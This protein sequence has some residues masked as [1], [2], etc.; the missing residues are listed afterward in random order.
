VWGLLTPE[1]R[2]RKGAQDLGL[3]L[4]GHAVQSMLKHLDILTHWNAKLNLTTLQDPNLASIYHFLDSLTICKL[5]FPV[6]GSTLLDVGTGAGFPGLPLKLVFPELRLIL[7]EKNPKKVVFLKRACHELGLKDVIFIN[8][9]LGSLIKEKHPQKYDTVVS[10]AF[11]SDPEALKL[12]GELVTDGGALISMLGPHGA[13]A[14]SPP[15]G[16]TVGDSWEG[17]LPFSDAYRKV[18]RLQPVAKPTGY[19]ESFA[20]RESVRPGND[21]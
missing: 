13:K 15:P 11:S 8:M 6:P 16:F 18:V 12:M 2:I 1:Q 10:R 4:E 19:M 20:D 7:L 21:P 3:E 5:Y 17:T 9:T 14:I